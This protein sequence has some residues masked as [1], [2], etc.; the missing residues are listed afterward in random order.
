MSVSQWARAI[1]VAC[2]TGRRKPC[3]RSGGGPAPTAYN[4]LARDTSA[5][6]AHMHSPFPWWVDVV[7][8]VVLFGSISVTLR[9]G[10]GLAALE[11]R[12]WDQTG[13]EMKYGRL[14]WG[15][16]PLCW[17]ALLAL[18]KWLPSDWAILAS[19]AIPCFVALHVV[20]FK[21]AQ[22]RYL[23]KVETGEVDPDRRRR[24]RKRSANWEDTEN[25]ALVIKAKSEFDRLYAH[26]DIKFKKWEREA[27]LKRLLEIEV[28]K[29]KEFDLEEEARLALHYPGQYSERRKRFLAVF[30]TRQHQSK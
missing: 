18:W 24:S 13:R 22:G 11:G 26:T 9:A 1:A 14:F 20:V 16:V 21:R 4:E 19:S 29:A 8:P 7:G 25:F 10:N 12:Y 6:F 17:L 5:C 23:D 2:V 28:R 30:L 15:S 27:E 3:Q